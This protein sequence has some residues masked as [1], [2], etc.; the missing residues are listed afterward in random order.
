VRH[1]QRR[2]LDALDDAGH[3]HRLAGAGGAQQRDHAVAVRQR[4]GGLVDGARLVGGR[5]EDGI[6]AKLGHDL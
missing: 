3:R 6:E 2:A 1:D 5:G 4:L